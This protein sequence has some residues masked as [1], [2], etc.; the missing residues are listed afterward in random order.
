MAYQAYFESGGEG[1]WYNCLLLTAP[2]ESPTTAPSKWT[3][4]EI[5]HIF[6]NVVALYAVAYILAAEGQSDKFRAQFAIASEALDELRM[7]AIDRG[8]A[9]PMAVL[10]R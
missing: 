4:L 3:R 2:G 7:T 8:D 1:D 9:K 6:E 10:T 5:P